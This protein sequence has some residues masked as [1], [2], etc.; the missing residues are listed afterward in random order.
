M[1]S[2]VGKIAP[3]FVEGFVIHIM[4][5]MRMMLLLAMLMREAIARMLMAAVARV[6]M[7][8]AALMRGMMRVMRLVTAVVRLRMRRAALR[9]TRR[10]MAR[11]GH[12]RSHLALARFGT[13]AF[14]RSGFPIAALDMMRRRTLKPAG[15][16]ERFACAIRA[17]RRTRRR[18]V[19][20]LMARN[21]LHALKPSG[22]ARGVD[23]V[24]ACR[25]LLLI[26]ILMRLD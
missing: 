26:A 19:M 13:A 25:R 16:V 8:V 21:R 24:I 14:R 10:L 17:R 15:Y 3:R 4:A 23:L 12:R 2:A 20:R 7:T 5:H 9:R 6:I 22:E 18:A 1:E 11:R